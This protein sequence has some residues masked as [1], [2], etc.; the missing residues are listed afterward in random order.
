[1]IKEHAVRDYNEG[2]HYHITYQDD[3]TKKKNTELYVTVR[4]NGKHISTEW[5]GDYFVMTYE[6]NNKIYELWENMEIGVMSQ[7][8]EYKKEE[9]EDEN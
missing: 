4:D 2:K 5:S 8:V 9:Y 7:V 1:M 3:V 6:Y